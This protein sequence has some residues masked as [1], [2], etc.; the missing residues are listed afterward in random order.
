MSLDR[1]IFQ[2]GTE[3]STK[4]VKSKASEVWEERRQPRT[5]AVMDANTVFSHLHH[6]YHTCNCA[7]LSGHAPCMLAELFTYTFTS[8]RAKDKIRKTDSTVLW[9]LGGLGHFSAREQLSTLG[10]NVTVNLFICF[11]AKLRSTEYNSFLIEEI[12]ELN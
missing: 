2:S 12:K 9:C 6:V 10:W 4:L 5:A 8:C 11:I 7:G 1:V 3:Q